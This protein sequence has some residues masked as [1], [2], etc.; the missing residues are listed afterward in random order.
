MQQQVMYPKVKVQEE[1]SC[2]NS[3]YIQ[4][5][6]YENNNQ[7]EDLQIYVTAKIPKVYIPSVSIFENE[8]KVINKDIREANIDS[9]PKP[10]TSPIL[11][12][13]AVVS[14]PDNDVMIGSINKSEEMK[15]KKGLKSSTKIAY[16]T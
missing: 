3:N 10:K 13:R 5:H 4:S 11:R 7:E 9:I 15:A 12:P 1:S 14:S 8:S 16:S 2:L 6:V